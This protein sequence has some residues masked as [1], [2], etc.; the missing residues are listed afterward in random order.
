M[1]VSCPASQYFG[2]VTKKG[3]GFLLP[4]IS[5]FFFKGKL[6][7]REKPSSLP[8]LSWLRKDSHRLLV[9]PEAL[10]SPVRRD[11]VLEAGL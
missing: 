2:L 4:R 7:P 3:I 10:C 11:G 5:G 9:L 6:R 8:S 1:S